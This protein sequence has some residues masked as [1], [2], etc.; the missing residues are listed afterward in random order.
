MDV[1]SDFVLPA[2]HPGVDDPEYRARRAAIA[3]ISSTWGPGRDVPRIAYTIDE[4]ELW[5]TAVDALVVR[6][7][8]FASRAFVEGA[9]RLDLPS[10]AVPH[11]ADVSRRLEQISGFSVGV[12]PGLVPTRE[13]YGSLADRTFL[14]TQYLRHPS[15]PFYT[16]EP[17]VI[18]EAVGHLN[19]LANPVFADLHRLAGEASRRCETDEALDFFSRVFWFTLEFG[20]TFERGELRAYGAGLASS[21]GE[22]EVFRQA[23]VR[24]FDIA[25]MGTQDY[26]I[27][28]Y[29]PILFAVE[30]IERLHHELGTFFAGYD[31]EEFE[32]LTAL[33]AAS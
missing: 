8:T 17:D 7:R 28:R 2:D 4:D 30:S 3:E 23:E 26:D 33:A 12:V 1:I 19:M 25:A 6:H 9:E 10:D 14:S 11:L 32:R 16:P 29:Q 13:F 22:L 20:V 24:P 27:T 21:I 31:D 15:V 18:H 5:A